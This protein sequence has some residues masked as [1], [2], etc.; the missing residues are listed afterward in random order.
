MLR[1]LV[2]SCRWN[3]VYFA[4][5]KNTFAQIFKLCRMCTNCG[6]ANIVRSSVVPGFEKPQPQPQPQPQPSHGQDEKQYHGLSDEEARWKMELERRQQEEK[7]SLEL[8]RQMQ[9]SE[10]QECLARKQKEEEETMKL[11]YSLEQEEQKEMLAKKKRQE[12]EDAAYIK[13]MLQQELDSKTYGCLV[14]FDE[15]KIE[16]MYTVDD[17]DHRFCWDCILSQVRTQVDSGNVE[18]KCCAANCKHIF[19]YEEL[20]LILGQRD[21]AELEKYEKFLLRKAIEKIPGSICCPKRGCDNMMIVEPGMTMARCPTCK[22][23]FCVNCK[24]GWHDDFTCQQYQ[25]WKVE[26]SQSEKR[27]QEWKNLH[28]KQCPHCHVPIE[29]NQGCNHMTCRSCHHEFCWLCLG[30]Y[31]HGNHFKRKGGCPQFS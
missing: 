19:G 23:A 7:E 30:D 27:F 21:P 10:N 29:K 8:I 12:D 9:E 5:Q 28:T 13:K 11:I 31:D 3:N 6:A 17:C 15:F 4:F 22:F 14:C 26:N 18:P 20:R 16:E 1:L 24:E 2:C 25:Q